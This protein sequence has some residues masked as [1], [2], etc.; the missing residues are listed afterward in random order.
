[1]ADMADTTRMKKLIV[2]LLLRILNSEFLNATPCRYGF[3]GN[4]DAFEYSSLESEDR[5]QPGI[6]V[7]EVLYRADSF[8]RCVVSM[9]DNRSGIALQVIE[10]DGNIRDANCW[11]MQDLANLGRK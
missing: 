10:D 9:K 3:I 7:R 2:D 5:Q 6:T 4:M 1:M 11:D 8:R